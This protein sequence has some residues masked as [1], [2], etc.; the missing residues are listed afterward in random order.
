MHTFPLVLIDYDEATQAKGIMYHKVSG[1]CTR[2]K[3]SQEHAPTLV[4]ILPM[5]LDPQ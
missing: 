4:T 1:S 3:T 5:D 2:S